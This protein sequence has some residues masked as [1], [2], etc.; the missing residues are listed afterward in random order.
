MDARRAIL[1]N[2]SRRVLIALLVA[3]YRM[4][5]DS[6]VAIGKFIDDVHLEKKCQ[7]VERVLAIVS[8]QD[9]SIRIVLNL[10]CY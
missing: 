5:G 10:P 4:R 3:K 1:Q 8:F 6:E 9:R 7:F 2:H